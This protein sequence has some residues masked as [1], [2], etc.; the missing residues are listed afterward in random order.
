[1]A[2]YQ[3]NGGGE[4]AKFDKVGDAV[5]GTVAGV[6]PV[7]NKFSGG[8]DLVI[9]VL[10]A[11]GIVKVRCD[12][13]ALRDAAA[14]VAADGG[15][16]VGERIIVAFEGTYDSK[17]Y[18]KGK[19][20]EISIDLPDRPDTGEASVPSQQ[21]VAPTGEFEKVYD[22]VVAAKGEPAAKAIRAAVAGVAKG[23]VA[24]QIELLRK[25]VAA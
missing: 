16:K 7:P 21:S 11:D 17:Q 13:K 18:G 10:T 9:Q 4:F 1:M 25:A 20:K 22:A 14:A 12:K 19:G 23:D 24:K 2:K 8:T 5:R 15:F 6:G 3:S